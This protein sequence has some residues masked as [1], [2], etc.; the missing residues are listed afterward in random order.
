LKFNQANSKPHPLLSV[1]GEIHQRE[2]KKKK[3]KEKP[4][5]PDKLPAMLEL[6][7]CA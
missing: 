6:A 4:V 7:L 3:R 2:Q 1:A 5:V